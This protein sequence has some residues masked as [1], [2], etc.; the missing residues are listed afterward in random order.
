MENKQNDLSTQSIDSTVGSDNKLILELEKKVKE[1]KDKL[2]LT[3]KIIV[4]EIQYLKKETGKDW[5]TRFLHLL[6]ETGIPLTWIMDIN[7]VEGEDE[8]NP[9]NV[10]IT[11]ISFTVKHRVLKDLNDY[12]ATEYNNIVYID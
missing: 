3:P 2:F 4:S 7:V 10:Y 8:K 1:M 5:K 11:L 9:N 6:F 12:L